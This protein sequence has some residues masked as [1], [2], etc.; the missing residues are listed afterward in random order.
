MKMV[1]D[2]YGP[3][4]PWEL[5]YSFDETFGLAFQR[6]TYSTTWI[7]IFADNDVEYGRHELPWLLTREPI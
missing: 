5:D 3:D 1:S 6:I 7:F 4:S 2:W